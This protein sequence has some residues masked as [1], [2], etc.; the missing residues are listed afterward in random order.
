VLGAG[1]LAA[2][3][4]VA[5]AIAC[6]EPAC[7]AAV[8]QEHAGKQDSED[9]G[10]NRSLLGRLADLAVGA[11]AAV[12][13]ALERAIGQFTRPG[14]ALHSGSSAPPESAS[15]DGAARLLPG[16]RS[17]FL[18]PGGP[19]DLPGRWCAGT[20]PL[21]VDFSQARAAGLDI[22]QESA[23]WERAADAWRDASGRAYAVR[24]RGERSIPVAD[25]AAAVDQGQVPDASIAV[26]YGGAPGSVP[27]SHAATVLAGQTA[28]YGGLTVVAVGPGPRDSRAESGYVL[29]DAPDLVAGLPD[30]QRRLQLYIHELGHALG[31][32][33]TAG[34]NSIMGPE[35][36]VESQEI[37]SRDRVALRSLAALPCHA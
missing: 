24:L 35:I 14:Q 12:D 6:T 7:R 2:Q 13:D 20:I 28:G 37:G 30:P 26:T 29:I 27:D 5:P 3:V 22:A 11:V 31:L 17:A 36:A 15:S 16:D 34:D 8:V 18:I 25:G 32:A 33:H 21:Y 9:A 10:D 19:T 4:S 1:I 23:L